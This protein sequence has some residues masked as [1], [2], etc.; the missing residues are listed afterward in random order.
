M[1]KQRYRIVPASIRFI[2]LKDA[3]RILSEQSDLRW[4]QLIDQMWTSY[5]QENKA[6]S[7]NM[8][9]DVLLVGRQG[10]VFHTLKGKS[11]ATAPIQLELQGA[12]MFQEAVIRCDAAYLNG[13]LELDDP[14]DIEEAALALYDSPKYVNYLKMVMSKWMDD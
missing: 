10:G 2:V 1:K 8:I 12:N 7:K 6:I 13:I 9:N 14:F 3:I 5:Q 11:L 4:R